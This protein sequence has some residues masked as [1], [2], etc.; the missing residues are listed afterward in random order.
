MGRSRDNG[1]RERR[2][3]RFDD[4]YDARSD[5]QSVKSIQAEFDER[6]KDLFDPESSRDFDDHSGHGDPSRRNKR[7]DSSSRSR[8]RSASR[9]E[10]RS[11]S[12][13]RS[14]SRSPSRARSGAGSQFASRSV[15]HHSGSHHSGSRREGSPQRSETHPDRSR[16]RSKSRSRGGSRSSSESPGKRSHRS[17]RSHRHR[18]RGSDSDE[19]QEPPED[20]IRRR[21]GDAQE[22]QDALSYAP[23]EDTLA[24]RMAYEQLNNLVGMSRKIQ[25]AVDHSKKVFEKRVKSANLKIVEKFFGAWLLARY[26]GVDKQKKLRRALMRMMKFRLAKTYAAWVERFGRKGEVWKMQRKAH[27]TIRRGRMKRTVQH[28]RLECDRSK[29]ERE[30]HF[31][32]KFLL[33]EQAESF[34]TKRERRALRLYRRRLLGRVWQALDFNWAERMRKKAKMNKA[35]MHM[36]KRK[37][38]AGWNGWH[39]AVSERRRRK[40]LLRKALKRM[41]NIKLARAWTK[42]YDVILAK[43][44]REGLLK[45]ALL[46]MKNRLM[47]AGWMSW[48][49]YLL[50]RKKKKKIMMRWMRPKMAAGYYGWAERVAERKARRAFAKGCIMKMLKRKLAMV[51]NKWIEFCR[52]MNEERSDGYIDKVK[53]ELDKLNGENAR[54]RRDNER[55]VRLIDS[56]SWSRSRVDEMARAGEVLKDERSE[57]AKLIHALRKDYA[58][59]ED[60]KELQAEELRA[61]KDR[62]LNGNFVQRNKLMVKGGSSFNG[63]VRA[64]KT[65]VL[66]TGSARR[67]PGALY[68]IDKLSMDHV[69]VFPDGEINVQAVK[70]ERE[71]MTQATPHQHSRVRLPGSSGQHSGKASSRP[72]SAS[73]TRTERI[74][75]A[76]PSL[77]SAG[78]RRPAEP[79]GN[80]LVDALKAMSPEEVDRL[81]DLMRREKQAMS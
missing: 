29:A 56:G 2:G 64:M 51:W 41:A 49:D 52:I 10:S 73:G 43:K 57:L 59:L 60:A 36:Q 80:K 71:P 55:F 24:A 18:R 35:L 25:D 33:N 81:E 47:G 53:A 44:R 74:R 76:S 78:K 63:L 50:W 21:E 58:A 15:S 30:A 37:L 22:M 65:D 42:W 5:A 7:D 40:D 4:D 16:S 66:E 68:A 70:R 79:N 3:S 12:K 39:Y 34:R 19:S 26:G 61:L 75:P 31:R 32:Q 38:A 77:G 8:S 45:K 1:D 20:E 9:R 11:R 27:A 14:K 62:L 67:Q 28:W 48:L 69:S 54:L 17:K 13:S 23:G 72:N 46:R 6:V